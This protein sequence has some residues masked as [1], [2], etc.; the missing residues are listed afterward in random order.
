[1]RRPNR[2]DIILFFIEKYFRYLL[3]QNICIIFLLE[4]FHILNDQLY[5]SFDAEDAAVDTQIVTIS[6]APLLGRIIVVVTLTPVSYTHLDVYKRQA[7]FSM[8]L[9][10]KALVNA[11]IH[12]NPAC[13]RLSSP[14]IPTVRF[15]DTA[16]IA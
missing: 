11:P 6:S 2:Q 16:R 4:V 13:P 7:L 3:F 12:I 8:T 9:E 14:R 15:R 5:G 1:M 10:K